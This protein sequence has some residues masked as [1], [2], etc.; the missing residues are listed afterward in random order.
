MISAGKR[1]RR[2]PFAATAFCSLIAVAAFLTVA[3]LA[4]GFA[5]AFFFVTLLALGLITFGV[6]AFFSVLFLVGIL[7]V[8]F[9]FGVESMT[10]SIRRSGL[11]GS[12][13]V[14]WRV[15]RVDCGTW[16]APLVDF[17]FVF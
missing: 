10:S 11:P 16:T 5:G 4:S 8:F 17:A 3:F 1:G 6:V 12:L 15:L 13:F 2:L 7:V 14:F 9:L